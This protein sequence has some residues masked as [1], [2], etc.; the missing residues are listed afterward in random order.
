MVAND[1]LPIEGMRKRSMMSRSAMT[2]PATAI[3]RKRELMTSLVRKTRTRV[4]SAG[5]SEV[6]P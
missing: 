1:A 6:K 5:R 3:P 2:K 4:V